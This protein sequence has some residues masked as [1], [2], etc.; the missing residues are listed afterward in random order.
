MTALA[1]D[2]VIT[3]VVAEAD[4]STSDA[5]LAALGRTG[6]VEVVGRASAG[7]EAVAQVLEVMPD[8]AL[9]DLDLPDVD[10]VGA[11]RQLHELAPAATLVVLSRSDDHDRAFAALCEGAT[12]CVDAASLDRLDEVV[13]G[14]TR[15]ECVLPPPLA[16]RVLAALEQAAAEGTPHAPTD[17]PPAPTAT[18][19]EVL[20]RLAEGQ[21]PADIAA[22]HDVTTRLVN[23]HSGFAVAKL[24]RWAERRH[25]LAERA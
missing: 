2:D 1:L 6:E 25:H 21:R 18:E 23:L 14:A 12:A 20:S 22:L 9:L 3:V 15:G 4:R 16:A 7:Q 11:C 5:A 19:R 8:A 10:A 24:Q 17:R 13:R